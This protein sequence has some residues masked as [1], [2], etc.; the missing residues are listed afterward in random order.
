MKFREI[1]IKKKNTQ[2][3]LRIFKKN[4]RYKNIKNIDNSNLNTIYFDYKENSEGYAT[5]DIYK[6]CKAIKTIYPIYPCVREESFL[7][8]KFVVDNIVF[9]V[10]THTDIF[11]YELIKFC[12]LNNMDL[13]ILFCDLKKSYMNFYLNLLEKT[14]KSNFLLIDKNS[15][16]FVFKNNFFYKRNRLIIKNK[17]NFFHSNPKFY[18]YIFKL[19]KNNIN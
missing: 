16:K 9:C 1:C 3:S 19:L 6:H 11:H 13:I 12:D 15:K 2:L 18:N 17:N 4:I 8:N 5:I 10:L 7:V 14:M